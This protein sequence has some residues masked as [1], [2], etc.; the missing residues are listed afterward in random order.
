MLGGY[1]RGIYE[2]SYEMF[3]GIKRTMCGRGVT[4]EGGKTGH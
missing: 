3:W 2:R 1:V 4:C